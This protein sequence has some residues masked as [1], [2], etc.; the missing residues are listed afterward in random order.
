M[1]AFF[2]ELIQAGVYKKSQGRITRQLTWGAIAL[3][4][5]LGLWRLNL[6][7]GGSQWDWVKNLNRSGFHFWLPGLLLLAGLW[8]GIR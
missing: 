1:N 5:G 4:L 3:I 2:H 8:V 7:L 6:T